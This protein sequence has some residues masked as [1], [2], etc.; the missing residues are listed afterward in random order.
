MF[1]WRG[2]NPGNEW[3]Y[4]LEKL[5][6]LYAEGRIKTDKAGKPLKRGHIQYL[7]EMK[8]PLVQNLWADVNNLWC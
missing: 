2:T 6:Q 5:E 1:E 4:S 8:N 7:D 3:H